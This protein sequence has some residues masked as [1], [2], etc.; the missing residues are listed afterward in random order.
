[1]TAAYAL[2]TPVMTQLGAFQ[3]GINT[4]VY[5]GLPRSDDWRWSDLEC[6]GQAS[7]PCRCESMSEPSEGDKNG[8]ARRQATLPGLA[9]GCCCSRF[10][11][12]SVPFDLRDARATPVAVMVPVTGAIAA[13]QSIS[14]RTLV[15]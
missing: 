11:R 4:A 14:C 15:F 1:M 6:F 13:C 8:R 12:F 7:H 10:H 9:P 3:F 5:L 2:A